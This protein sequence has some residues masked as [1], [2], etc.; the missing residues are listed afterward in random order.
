MRHLGI[1]LS[2][3]TLSGCSDSSPPVIEMS[4]G[5]SP[6][7]W[8]SPEPATD[9]IKSFHIV[10]PRAANTCR[11]RLLGAA[12]AITDGGEAVFFSSDADVDQAVACLKRVLPEGRFDL[13]EKP[14]WDQLTNEYPGFP[15]PFEQVPPLLEPP[16]E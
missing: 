14:E 11:V 4:F 5:T 8:N 9:Y 6:V 16:P 10:I 1:S 7:I 13:I 2:F 15:I 12:G 3:M